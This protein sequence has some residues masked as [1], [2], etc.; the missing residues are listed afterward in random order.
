MI[1]CSLL[2]LL[3]KH[4][5]KRRNFFFLS[6]FLFFFLVVLGFELSGALPLEPL[7]HVSKVLWKYRITSEFRNFEECS[8]IPFV[9]KSRITLLISN[10]EC[11]SEVKGK[12]AMVAHFYSPSTEAECLRVLGQPGLHSKTLSQKQTDTK[13]IAVSQKY[14][15]LHPNQVKGNNILCWIP[16]RVKEEMYCWALSFFLSEE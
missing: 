1:P 13:I 15:P 5:S 4:V 16:G 9:M 2:K 11:L 8:E 6:F 10:N 14:C 12:L 3:Q 7:P